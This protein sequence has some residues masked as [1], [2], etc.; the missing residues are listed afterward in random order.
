MKDVGIND[1][2]IEQLEHAL[3]DM[4]EVK[5]GLGQNL[6]IQNPEF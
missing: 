5:D 3:S 2:F 1:K 6:K 4:E